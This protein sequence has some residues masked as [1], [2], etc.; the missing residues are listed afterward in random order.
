MKKPALKKWFALI[1]VLFLATACAATSGG[2]EAKR[3][4]LWHKPSGERVQAIYWADGSY[5]RATMRK[6]NQLFRDR[7]TGEVHPID[8]NLIRLIDELLSALALPAGTEVE[9]TSGF[10]SPSRNA[11]LAERN[12]NVAR[13]SYHTKGQAAD[14][15][16]AGV[17]GKAVSAVAQTIQGGGVAFYP[18]SGHIHVDT[19]TVRTWKPKQ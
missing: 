3:I 14:I 11:D 13:Q 15:R 18:K 16:I 5:N 17:N 12:E 9:L 8:P 4:N 7:T 10:R 19:G 1:A 2:A 6:I